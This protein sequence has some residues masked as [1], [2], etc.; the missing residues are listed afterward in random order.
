MGVTLALNGFAASTWI[1]RIPATRD[2][3]IAEPRTLGFMLLMTGIGAL[4]FMPLAGRL[5]ARFGSRPVLIGSTLVAAPLLIAAALTPN[6]VTTGMAMFALGAGLGTAD[7]VINVQGSYVDRTLDR[8][9]MPRY[10]AGWSLGAITGAALGALAARLGWQLWQ[11]FALASMI[12]VL[13]TLYF[14][15]T[16]Y[17][18]DRESAEDAVATVETRQSLLRNRRIMTIGIL[19]LA[20]VFLEGSA[21]DWLGLFLHD[22]RGTT[23]CFGALGYATFA[24]AMALIRIAGTPIIARYGRARTIRIAG[25]VALIGVLTV[26]LVPIT[27]VALVGVLMWGIGT[28]L[29][30]PAGMSASGETPGRSAEAISLVSVIGYAGFLV[31]PPIVGIIAQYIGLSHA[32]WVV[33]PGAI[34]IAV[35]APVVAHTSRSD[36]QTADQS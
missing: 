9:Y 31:G 25:C 22:V 33:V 1:S 7:V 28:G 23:Q 14:A 8:D 29:V 6:P 16:W 2:R 24:L 32:L 4:A 26:L 15:L 19:V 18:D 13:A 36:M 5:A 27:A 10:H 35:L 3:L 17:V 11:H 20:A 12:F 21:G 34:A 30:Y